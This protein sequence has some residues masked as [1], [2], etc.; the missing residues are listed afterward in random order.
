MADLTLFTSL[1]IGNFLPI[2]L[3]LISCQRVLSFSI[4]SI[5][6][7]DVPES[8]PKDIP[9]PETNQENIF[10]PLQDGCVK[11]LNACPLTEE[12]SNGMKSLITGIISSE[13]FQEKAKSKPKDAGEIFNLFT[14]AALS[15]FTEEEQKYIQAKL[16][17][18]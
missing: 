14:N 18:M 5:S 15:V 12:Q 13:T 8:E 9:N 3:L 4:S 10:Q 17:T 2:S 1:F 16:K 7:I 6:D 11:F